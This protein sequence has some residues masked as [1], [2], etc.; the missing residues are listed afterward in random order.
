[1]KR[2]RE[3]L[4][5]LRGLEIS[6]QSRKDAVARVTAKKKEIDEQIAEA[7]SNIQEDLNR[8]DK[9][10]VEFDFVTVQTK[11]V[12]GKVLVFDE[13]IIPSMFFIEQEPKLDKKALKAALK[14]GPVDGAGMSN[15]GQTVSITFRELEE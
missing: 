1:M 5:R 13:A 9:T 12:P 3:N 10:K 14:D 6:L 2:L 11:P 4:E 8:M 7:R 15:G